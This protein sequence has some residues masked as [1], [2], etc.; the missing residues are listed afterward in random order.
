MKPNN[1][2]AIFLSASFILVLSIQSC[3]DKDE[4]LEQNSSTTEMLC[5][6]EWRF[7]ALTVN[8]GIDFGDG[9]LVTDVF[10][11]LDA[12]GTDDLTKYN[13][14]KTG[15]FSSGATKCDPNDPDTGS[16]TWDISTDGSTFSEDNQSYTIKEISNTTFVR[17]FVLLGDSI[18]QDPG[19][20]YTYT[21]TLEH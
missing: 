7:T 11:L 18:G 6:S 13:T 14:N 17:T 4:P 19:V 9:T 15:V 10:A 3:K 16:F 21:F 5:K 20:N 12:C 2:K 8:P 1:L